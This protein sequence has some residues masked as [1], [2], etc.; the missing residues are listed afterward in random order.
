MALYQGNKLISGGGVQSDWN[1]NDTEAKDYVKNRTHYVDQ[2]FE[3]TTIADLSVATDEFRKCG[4][5]S[6]AYSNTFLLELGTTYRVTIDGVSYI[7]TV[8][9]FTSSMYALGN[10]EYYGLTH[11]TDASGGD[12]N[13]PFCISMP[14]RDGSEVILHTGKTNTTHTVSIDK[15]T[16]SIVK[17]DEKFLPDTVATKPSMTRITLSASSWDATA[18]TQS[19]TVTGISADETAQIIQCSPYGASMAAAVESG[20]YCSGQA[21]DS[22]TF[23]CTSVPTEDVQ[24]VVSWQDCVWIEPPV[25]L[26]SFSIS[27]VNYQA[28]EGMIWEDW[29]DSEY[30]TDGF[31]ISDDN[32]AVIGSNG[33]GWV[34]PIDSPHSRPIPCTEEI[35]SEYEYYWVV[36]E[37]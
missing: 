32:S 8:W 22:L 7:T 24:F 36:P 6:E 12:T 30:N 2:A 11:N 16:E 17:L 28:E 19:V 34:A 14:T 33:L 23:T 9:Q 5:I 27:G 18:L 3:A 26:I 21:A 25:P 1:Q 10:A 37:D 31:I 29:I 4:Y 15:V 35:M 20:I 13:C